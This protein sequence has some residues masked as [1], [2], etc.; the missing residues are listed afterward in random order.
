M[1][2]FLIQTLIGA[3]FFFVFIAAKYIAKGQFSFKYWLSDN[4]AYFLWSFAVCGFAALI[5]TFEPNAID[6]V[7]GNFGIT[8]QRLQDGEL[9]GTLLGLSIALASRVV[10]KPTKE[11]DA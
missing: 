9:S 10:A 1:L 4:K 6:A 2:T 7:F 5:A 3:M 11:K 8:V